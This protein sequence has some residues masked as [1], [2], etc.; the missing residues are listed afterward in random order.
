MALSTV[1]EWLNENEQ[2]AYPL[3]IN[4]TR[5]H[6]W[7]TST[8]DLFSLIVDANLVYTV[9]L[10]EV[11][12]IESLEKVGTTITIQI[13]GLPTFSATI[14][15]DPLYIRSNNSLI[16]LKN[17]GQLVGDA[18]LTFDSVFIEPSL[19]IEITNERAGVATMQ[20]NGI[21]INSGV[22]NLIEGKQ[23]SLNIANNVLFVEVG[24]NEGIPIGCE[25]YF[26]D[27]LTYDCP[28]IISFINGAT[29]TETA[30]TIK[31][32]AG[33][34]IRIYEDN[35]KNRIYIGLG[36]EP[37]DICVIPTLPPQP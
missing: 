19:A 26:E 9:E 27:V 15:E 23:T 3:T 8:I 30:G 28:S 10:P 13:T 36:F 20:F 4:S 17:L 5:I 11:I 37:Q 21:N 22:V 1:V 31:L 18:S 2:R 29:V 24:R 35:E 34:N 6:N 33:D 12:K 25:D 7:N 32:I 16:V 14:S